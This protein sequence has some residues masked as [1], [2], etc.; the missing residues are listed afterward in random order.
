[1]MNLV[2][3]FAGLLVASSASAQTI[4]CQPH[5]EGFYRKLDIT[6]PDVPFEVSW[7]SV[8]LENKHNQRKIYT[9]DSVLRN[10]TLQ[11]ISKEGRNDFVLTFPEYKGPATYHSVQLVLKQGSAQEEKADLMCTVSEELSFPNSCSEGDQKKALFQAASN[12]NFIE[13]ESALECGA[14]GN[15]KNEFGCTAL[16]LTAD[17]FCGQVLPSP[18]VYN[19]IQ[20][21]LPIVDLLT[22]NGAI[23]DSKDPLSSETALHKFTK[24]GDFDVVSMLLDLEAEV[25]AQD[26]L[27]FTSLMRAVEKNDKFLVERIIEAG[28]D[29]ALKNNDGETALAIAVK[30]GLKKLEPLLQEP[31]TVIEISGQDDGLCSPQQVQLSANKLNKIVLKA[32]DSKMFLLEATELGL[33]LMAGAGGS[34]SQNIMPK[35][36][37]TFS[38]TCGVHG[39]DKQTNGQITVQ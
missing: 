17:P 11:F 15:A 9:V 12:R 8:R 14:S 4:N 38:F 37:G 32:T 3:L 26:K 25:D 33:N 19:P 29:L 36:T 23:V 16:L 34:V 30:L 28:P 7:F 27:G 18:I 5:G 1:M 2:L 24:L 6:K 22:N 31:S 21:A 13:L 39:A 35:Q 20:K 10:Q